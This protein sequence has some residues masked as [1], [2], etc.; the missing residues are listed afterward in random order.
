MALSSRE[1][2][3]TIY[4]LASE[5]YSFVCSQCDNEFYLFEQFVEHIQI[6]LHEVL[7]VFVGADGTTLDRD[8]AIEVKPHIQCQLEQEDADS[9]DI[10]YEALSPSA[11]SGMLS[12][13]CSW[14]M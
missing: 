11:A 14:I 4:H 13:S 10:K 1:K 2:I 7:T 8:D 5:Q 12:T 9:I 3:G 6:H